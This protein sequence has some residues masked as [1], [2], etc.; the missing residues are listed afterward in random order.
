V[1]ECFTPTWNGVTNSVVRVVDHLERRGHQVLV[2]A[3][4]LG[5]SRCGG[6]G[7]VGAGGSRCG[8]SGTTAVERVP[9]VRLPAYRSLPVGIPTPGVRRA[10]ERFGPDVV[11]PTAGT[12]RAA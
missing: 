11:H 6:D 12:L 4:G 5:P 1:T 10:L 7:R 3:P 8:P 9:A 2:V